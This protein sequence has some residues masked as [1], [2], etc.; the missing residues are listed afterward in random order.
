MSTNYSTYVHKNY[1][2]F[3]YRKP[4][5]SELS[6]STAG[7]RPPEVCAISHGPVLAASIG[8]PRRV[9]E[10][11]NN[12]RFYVNLAPHRGNLAGNQLRFCCPSTAVIT[13]FEFDPGF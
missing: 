11:A 12:L 2:N 6:S 13:P 10:I 3:V 1:E 7:Y 9:N 4:D 8:D 5:H